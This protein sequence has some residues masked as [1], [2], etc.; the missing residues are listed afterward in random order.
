MRL[1]SVPSWT[2]SFY[3]RLVLYRKHGLRQVEEE[4]PRLLNSYLL[5]KCCRAVSLGGKHVGNTWTFWKPNFHPSGCKEANPH[6]CFFILLNFPIRSHCTFF[7]TLFFFPSSYSVKLSRVG[8]KVKEIFPAYREKQHVKF[9]LYCRKKYTFA[10][11]QSMHHETF[12]LL[13]LNFSFKSVKYNVIVLAEGQS[14]LP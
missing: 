11:C 6:K 12:S 14:C 1:R 9:L 3:S 4:W 5:S 7:A 13:Y 2:C 10:G 8:N